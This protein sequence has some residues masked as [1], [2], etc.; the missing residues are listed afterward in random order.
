MFASCIRF[1]CLAVGK[2]SFSCLR[3]EEGERILLDG[4]RNFD[5]PF[6]GL[7]FKLEVCTQRFFLVVVAA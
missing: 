3:G 1:F 7:A 2:S 5:N 6:V 4:A